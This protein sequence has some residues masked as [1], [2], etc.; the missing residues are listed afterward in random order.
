[1]G[2]KTKGGYQFGECNGFAPNLE[3]CYYYTPPAGQGVTLVHE[4]YPQNAI[5]TGNYNITGR[6]RIVSCILAFSLN[7]MMIY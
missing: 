7:R 1:M 5:R 2:C 6:K 4:E 3:H